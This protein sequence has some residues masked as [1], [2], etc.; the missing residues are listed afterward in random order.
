MYHRLKG[1]YKKIINIV[2]IKKIIDNIMKLLCK[3]LSDYNHIE[4]KFIAFDQYYWN[5]IISDE[6]IVKEK[7]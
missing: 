6:S 5:A 2:L 3:L 7:L 1:Y 4:I